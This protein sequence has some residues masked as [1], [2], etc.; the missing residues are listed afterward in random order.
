MSLKD[1]WY[2]ACESRELRDKP[3]SRVILGEPIVVFR[4]TE[5]AASALSDRCAHRNMAL[6][7]GCVTEKGLQ[8][9][10]HGWTYDPAG[11]CVLVPAAGEQA[12]LPRIGVRR[13]P[14]VEQDG[15]VW[16]A[17]GGVRPSKEPF[18]FPHHRQPGWT[19]FSMQ[20]R[21]EASP[22]NC[23]ENFLDCPHTVFVHHG[24]F[25]TPDARSLSAVLRRDEDSVEVRFKDLH[26]G[27]TL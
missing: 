10:Y 9:G 11:S 20:N 17:P 24:W 16:V 14:A 2:I 13:F 18:A 26:R 27:R 1:H 19:S 15:Y 7:L 21:F 5:G 22:E 4:S 3:L 25:R 8:C 12:R 23:L 6:S